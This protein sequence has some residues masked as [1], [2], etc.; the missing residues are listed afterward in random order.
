MSGS[1]SRNSGNGSDP[2]RGDPL[3]VTSVDQSGS[4]LVN[5]LLNGN[6]FQTWSRAIKIALA[7]NVKIGFMTGSWKTPEEIR[8]MD[9]SG[10]NSNELD[11]AQYG[12][13]DIR[14]LLV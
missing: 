3:F 10:F 4:G 13:R 7:A 6:N 11:P 8:A 5:I 12:S 9:K 1:S 14:C 2:Y